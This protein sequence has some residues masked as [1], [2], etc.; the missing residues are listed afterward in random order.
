M[1]KLTLKPVNRETSTVHVHQTG[2]LSVCPRLLLETGL[3]CLIVTWLN[4]LLARS[5]KTGRSNP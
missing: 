4:L 2:F 1:N 3:F 5:R